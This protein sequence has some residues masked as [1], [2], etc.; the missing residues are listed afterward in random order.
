[1]WVIRCVWLGLGLAACASPVLPVASPP[2]SGVAVFPTRQ[3][4]ASL[5]D[6][7]LAATISLIDPT[8]NQTVGT[9]LTSTSGKFVFGSLSGVVTDRPYLLEAVKGLSSHAPGHDAVRLRTLV[10]RGSRGWTSLTGIVPG[11]S[12]ILNGTTTAACIV[13]SLKQRV[14]VNVP[15]AN[16]LGSITLGS[17]ALGESDTFTDGAGGLSS[18]EVL[19]AR[20][21]TITALASDLDP[22]ACIQAGATGSVLVPTLTPSANANPYSVS[23]I[24]PSTVVAGGTVTVTLAG[25]PPANLTFLFPTDA[26]ASVVSS[27]GPTFTLS[28]PV[29]ATSGIFRVVS[30][31]TVATGSVVVLPNLAGKVRGG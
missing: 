5:S 21:Q 23:S 19:L 17:Q 18:A 10:N 9:A 7:A 31:G 15:L 29:N 3:I 13:T 6:V 25:T 27:L 1:M 26:T 2:L 24:T 4:Q 8:L 20:A 12:I 28:V 22:I 14:G 30:T 16:L 11:S